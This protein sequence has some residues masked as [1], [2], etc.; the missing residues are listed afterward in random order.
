MVAVYCY[1]HTLSASKDNIFANLRDE[2][3]IN[4]A[5]YTLK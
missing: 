3:V 2:I 5:V 1:R 4:E